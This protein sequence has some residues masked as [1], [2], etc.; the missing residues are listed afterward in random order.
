MPIVSLSLSL[1]L[2]SDS[3]TRYF[4]SSINIAW[5]PQVI[6]ESSLN[7]NDLNT[8]KVSLS[9]LLLHNVTPH[10]RAAFNYDTEIWIINKEQSHT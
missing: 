4:A 2:E 1:S 7:C 10:Q 9:E 3:S 8:R 5:M 6:H